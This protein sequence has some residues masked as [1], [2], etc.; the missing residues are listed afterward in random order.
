L[1]KTSLG[2][3]GWRGGAK[4][5]SRRN[6]RLG[7]GGLCDGRGAVWTMGAFC[8]VTKILLIRF[9][10]LGDAAVSIAKVASLGD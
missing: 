2:I 1:K 9:K 8:G 4:F 10:F 7:G 6:I 3:A 5:I